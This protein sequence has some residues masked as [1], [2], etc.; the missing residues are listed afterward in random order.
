MN[1]LERDRPSIK[2]VDKFSFKEVM[3][4]A[5]SPHVIMFFIMAF[6][7]STMTSGFSFFLPSIVKQL[8]FSPKV[9][10]LL[11]AGPSAAG[12]LG[13]NCSKCDISPGLFTAYSSNGPPV[14]LMTAFLSDRYESRGITAATVT[15]LAVAGFALYLGNVLCLNEISFLE[16]TC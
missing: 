2:P 16:V 9:T 10:Q 3:L 6:I 7:H 11:S 12:A 4:S 13:E 14:T 5:C 15:M 1:R 8:G